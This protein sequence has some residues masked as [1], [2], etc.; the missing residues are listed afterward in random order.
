MAQIH[1]EEHEAESLTQD[2]AAVLTY[3]SGLY[4][5][6]QK[7]GQVPPLETQINV[8]REDVTQPCDPSLVS[9]SA[10]SEADF[11][12]VPRIIKQG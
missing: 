11:F 10:E 5:I 7:Y 1:L 4:D 2:I 6:A 12:V 3:A 9:L 8:F